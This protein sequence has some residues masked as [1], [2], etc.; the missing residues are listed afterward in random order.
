MLN[1]KRVFLSVMKF[2][3]RY[4]HWFLAVVCIWSCKPEFP[5]WETE[6]ILPLADA[7]LYLTNLAGDTILTHDDDGLLWLYYQYSLTDV[8]T[9]TLFSGTDTLASYTYTSPF[10]ITLPPGAQVLNKNE[11]NM[12]KI[13][14]VYLK[15]LRISEGKLLI[16]TSNKYLQPIRIEYSIPDAT[17][18]GVPFSIIRDIPAAPSLGQPYVYEEQ[19]NI[20]QLRWVF[21]SNGA[22]NYNSYHSTFKLWI[23]PNATEHVT[24]NY[25]DQ[26]T[27]FIGFDDITI[28]YARGYFGQHEYNFS[29][30][31]V[32]DLF[33]QFTADAFKIDSVELLL[34][35]TN[36]LGADMRLR[37]YELKGLNEQ[38]GHSVS[39]AGPFL[40]TPI[41]IIRAPEAGVEQGLG[42]VQTYV[43]DLSAQS[44]LKQFIENMPTKVL[45]N[46]QFQL[47]PLGNVSGGNDYYYG[48]PIN[49]NLVFRM[50]LNVSVENLLLTDT[51]HFASDFLKKPIQ[52][53]Q[54][55]A[56]VFNSFPFT[57]QMNMGFLDSNK[58]HLCSIPFDVPVKEA[59]IGSN[60]RTTAPEKTT[61]TVNIPKEK[62]EIIRNASFVILEFSLSTM[63]FGQNVRIFQDYA[64]DVR[65]YA[66]VNI[67]IQ[68]EE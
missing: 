25:N 46:A 62:I 1:L 21:F 59:L 19:I 42:T 9:D 38:T 27:F 31:T 63:P 67:L 34:E 15:V 22:G 35:V 52:S 2:Y 56:I 23:S 16:K 17:I 26:F 45:M 66:L 5:S 14:N 50:P 3:K 61:L 60:G 51:L 57:F 32:V 47:N 29:D 64:I 55:K 43:I 33:R 49:A 28:D 8:N 4:L 37:L 54:L 11:I 13:Q 36:N 48:Q 53:L 7:R 40:N 65:T 39:Y 44:N 10:T 41:N 12:L 58:V 20:Q 24:V 68:Q 30:E 18:G 6:L